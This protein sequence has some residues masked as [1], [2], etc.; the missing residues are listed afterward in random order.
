ME[1]GNDKARAGKR[2]APSEVSVVWSSWPGWIRTHLPDE[3]DLPQ[4]KRA[5]VVRPNPRPTPAEADPPGRP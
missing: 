1:Q 3:G 2:L 5:G 4:P